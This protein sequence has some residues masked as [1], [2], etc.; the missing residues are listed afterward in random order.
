[1]LSFLWQY[2]P[3]VKPVM[4]QEQLGIM[5]GNYNLSKTPYYLLQSRAS[6][7]FLCPNAEG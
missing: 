7:I 3:S 5:G 1:M 2:K 4:E 6:I